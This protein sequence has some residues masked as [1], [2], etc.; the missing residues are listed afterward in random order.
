M[1]RHASLA[2]QLKAV[3]SYRNRPDD[4]E[5]IAPVQ[6]NWSVIPANDNNPEDL[7]N[8]SFERKRLITPSVA[9]I[10]RNIALDEEQKD[11][12]GKTVRIGKLRFSDGTQT[13]KAYRYTID[14]KMQKYDARMPVGAMLGC[15]DKPDTQ[16]GGEDDPQ[17]RTNSNRYFAEMLKTSPHRYIS[18]SG[19]R[20]NGPGCS[21]DQAKAILDNA[22]KN[23]DMDSISISKYPDALP[24]GSARASDSFLGMKKAKTGESGSMMWQDISTSM[25]NR[26]I[27]AS[28]VAD[29]PRVDLEVLDAVSTASSLSDIGAV[30]GYKGKTAE[31]RGKRALISAN[32]N[33]MDAIKYYRQ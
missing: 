10:M 14:G 21:R 23:T 30:V 11:Q 9:E 24:C 1:A 32:Q 5:P 8:F 29:M 20:R 17:E 16:L 18:A 28:V 7:E 2:E 13:E 15:R 33:L 27:W 31:R 3:L 26:E 25:V 6:T 19:P 22:I 4:D 12:S